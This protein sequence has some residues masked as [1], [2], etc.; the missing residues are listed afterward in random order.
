MEQN[1]QDSAAQLLKTPEGKGLLQ[2]IKSIPAE[3]LADIR[4]AVEAG[5]TELAKSIVAPWLRGGTRNG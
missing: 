1:F 3:T 2:I 4:R 5:D